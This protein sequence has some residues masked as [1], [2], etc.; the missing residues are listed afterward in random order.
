[1][2][3]ELDLMEMVEGLNGWVVDSLLWEILPLVGFQNG[4]GMLVDTGIAQGRS[5]CC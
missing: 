5:V 3:L 4:T 1:M 2:L